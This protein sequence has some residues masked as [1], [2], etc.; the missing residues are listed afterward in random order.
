MN[1]ELVTPPVECGLLPGTF[2]AWLL[3]RGEVKEKVL[4]IDALK[5]AEEIYVVNSVRKWQNA[6]I[7]W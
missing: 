2:R 6:V 7:L 4:T 5:K 1:G 3:D